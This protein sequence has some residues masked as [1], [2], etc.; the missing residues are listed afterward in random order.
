ML[1]VK[2]YSSLEKIFLDGNLPS[3][4]W[5]GM[6]CLGGE[7]CAFQAVVDLEGWG[8]QPG[9]VSVESALPVEVFQVGQVPSAL[10]CYPDA[11]EDPD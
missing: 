9:T 6:S 7:E 3:K 11:L 8:T 1:S 5:S 2:L 4:P 10:A